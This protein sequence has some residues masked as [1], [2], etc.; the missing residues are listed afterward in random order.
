MRNFFFLTLIFYTA[1][2]LPEE[3]KAKG[4]S[5][6]SNTTIME[7]SDANTAN[8]ASSDSSNF[9]SLPVVQ[10]IKSPGGIYRTVLPLKNKIEQTIAFNSDLTYQLQE[11][12]FDGEK[13]SV[14]FTEGTWTPSDGFIWLY[15]DQIAS[16]RYKWK[17]DTLQ[18]YSPLL[19]KNFSMHH[20]NDATQ[21]AAWKNK[22]KAG[23]IL[24]GTGNEPFWNI[25][26]S[27]KDSIVFSLAEWKQ[28][29][30]IKID[31]SFHS[32]DSTGYIA[33]K[34]STQIRV[35]IFPH[36]CSDGMSDFVYRNKVKVQYNHQAYAGCGIVY[37]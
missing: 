6:K 17:L 33:G 31:S 32:I 29:V 22:G 14:V 30:K 26:I 21:N 4:L 19:K 8:D 35:T 37:K 25:E 24:F 18:Y 2:S 3:K 11:K 7:T 10:K 1:C 13:D 23:I 20:L 16:G 9:I 34:D 12:Y 27:K 15:K 36:F 28:P 5:E